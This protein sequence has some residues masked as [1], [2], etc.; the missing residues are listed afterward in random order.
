MEH[1]DNIT[2]DNLP[3]TGKPWEPDYIH[4]DLDVDATGL[5]LHAWI[6]RHDPD[7]LA[8][9]YWAIWRP[10]RSRTNATY[11]AK[12]GANAEHGSVGFMV[13]ECHGDNAACPAWQ[14][15]RRGNNG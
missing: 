4:T 15:Y 10:F 7:T 8:P 3:G 2:P 1:D 6:L 11:H 13:I 14:S 12:K 9:S 5:H